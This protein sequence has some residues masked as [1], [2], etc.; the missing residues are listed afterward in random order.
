[1]IRRRQ[2]ITLLGGAAVWPLAENWGTPIVINR[3]CRRALI[4][5]GRL[6]ASLSTQ[7][8]RNRPPRL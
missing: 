5:L 2:F 1:M 7:V 4:G 8:P 6:L 3:L